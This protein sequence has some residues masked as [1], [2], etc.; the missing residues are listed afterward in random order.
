MNWMYCSMEE[1]E[2][3][4]LVLQGSWGG[5]GGKSLRRGGMARGVNGWDLV[6]P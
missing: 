3:H 2:S 4:K 1:G 5:F 6:Q